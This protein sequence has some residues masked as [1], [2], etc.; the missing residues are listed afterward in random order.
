MFGHA[1]FGASYYGPSYWGPG[2]GGAGST[3]LF[4]NG[5]SKA[6][7]VVFFKGI[8]K[9]NIVLTDAGGGTYTVAKTHQVHNMKTDSVSDETYIIDGELP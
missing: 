7:G 1:Y 3:V 5:I 4:Y 8:S 6:N 2:V 9:P